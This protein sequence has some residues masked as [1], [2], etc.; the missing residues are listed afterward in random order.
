MRFIG[1]YSRNG[2]ETFVEIEAEN[3]DEASLILGSINA[4]KEPVDCEDIVDYY[5]EEKATEEEIAE[6]RTRWNIQK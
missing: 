5:D 1:M 4:F 3:F 6:I 2:K